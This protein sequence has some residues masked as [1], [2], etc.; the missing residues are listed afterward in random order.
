MAGIGYATSWGEIVAAWRHM[1]YRMASDT[2][3]ETL[4]LDGPLVG[5]TFRW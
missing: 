1:E 4:K 3:I 5:A 2:A